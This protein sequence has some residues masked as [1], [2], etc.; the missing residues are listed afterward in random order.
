MLLLGL[1]L[2]VCIRLSRSALARRY[3]GVLA[4][5][6]VIAPPTRISLQL[7]QIGILMA[8]VM[9]RQL[10][11][12]APPAPVAGRHAA[13]AGGA[14]Q[15]LPGGAGR[16]LRTAAARRLGVVLRPAW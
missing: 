8:L 12:G 15:D 14:D 9:I 5:L 1:L 3:W 6:L 2:A 4:L 13:G 11:A 16:L 10:C 7:G